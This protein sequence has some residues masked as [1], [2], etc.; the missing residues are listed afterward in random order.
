MS[1]KYDSTL[2]H[3]KMTSGEYENQVMKGVRAIQEKEYIDL[4]RAP[5]RKLKSEAEDF[6]DDHDW[7]DEFD[8]A[9]LGA[10]VEFSDADKGE[11]T[12]WQI[13]HGPQGALEEMAREAMV[14]DILNNV[15]Q[16][17]Y[18]VESGGG[19]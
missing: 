15:R 9:T 13:R 6:V 16:V 3:L 12:R 5:K 2:D 19:R 10:I 7:F 11:I 8:G 1:T 17:K 14:L 18:T 4:T